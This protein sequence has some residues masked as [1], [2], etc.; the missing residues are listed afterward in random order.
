MFVFILIRLFSTYIYSFCRFFFCI[1]LI[2]FHSSLLELFFSFIP[3]L[4][5]IFICLL[6]VIGS[7]LQ[8]YQLNKFHSKQGTIASALVFY[9]ERFIPKCKNTNHMWFVY[10]FS[11]LQFNTCIV[12]H[13]FLL[14]L[15]TFIFFLF[16][17]SYYHWYVT[18]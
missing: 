6:K 9:W 15:S 10:L 4:S 1:Y 3:T 12:S 8:T 7:K 13:F 17:P 11:L 2:F 16:W 14:F 5:F 18:V